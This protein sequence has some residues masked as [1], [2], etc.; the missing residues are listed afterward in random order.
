MRD[1][2]NL[3]R[4]PLAPSA[5]NIKKPISINPL[6][7]PRGVCHPIFR[8]SPKERRMPA[9]A[10][11]TLPRLLRSASPTGPVNSDAARGV[12][13]LSRCLCWRLEST[14]PC[15]RKR[16]S[17]RRSL[18]EACLLPGPSLSPWR[19]HGEVVAGDDAAL[20]HAWLPKMEVLRRQAKFPSSLS[21]TRARC[22]GA[23]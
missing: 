5:P 20:L 13:K 23:L 9:A 4:R 2:Y 17:T 21:P 14:S 8:Y 18:R 10:V 7:L 6:L 15:I 19:P 22:C 3:N 11:L 12:P 16:C 1:H